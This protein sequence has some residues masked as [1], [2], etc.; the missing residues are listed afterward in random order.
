VS[1]RLPAKA[2]VITGTGA[3]M[4]RATALVLAREGA[5]T[6]GCDVTVDPAES[7]VEMVRGAAG[8]MV[9][10]QPCHLDDSAGIDPGALITGGAMQQ[11][12]APLAGVNL[13]RLS[14]AD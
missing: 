2:C 9:S 12:G 8:E 11:L 1:G 10:I 6:V 5:S 13:I 14:G 7:T 3:S 4:G